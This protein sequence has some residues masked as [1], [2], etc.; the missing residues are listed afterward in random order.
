MVWPMLGLNMTW[1]SLAIKSVYWWRDDA[2]GSCFRPVVA[3]SL[4]TSSF[5]LLY[6]KRVASE[7]IGHCSYLEA[8]VLE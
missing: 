3:L 1:C 6:L 7:L 8:G 5:G 2:S 4:V